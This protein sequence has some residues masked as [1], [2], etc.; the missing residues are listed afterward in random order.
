MLKQRP[1][2]FIIELDYHAEVLVELCRTLALKFDLMLWTTS[3]IWE[4]INLPA[5][6]FAHTFIMPKNISPAAYAKQHLTNLPDYDFV[7]FNTLERHFS[8]FLNWPKKCPWIIRI[9]NVNAS[10]FPQ[11]SIIWSL[12]T[13]FKNFRY[14]IQKVAI[15]RM[16]QTR[17]ALYHKIDSLMLPSDA[18][19][20]IQKSALPV[21]LAAKVANYCL[22]FSALS[23]PPQYPAESDNFTIAVTG[24]V[25]K[26]RKDYTVLLAAI[27]LFIYHNPQTHL[28][29]MFLGRVKGSKALR[30]LHPFKSLENGIFKV[31]YQMGYLPDEEFKIKMQKVHLLV[32]PI[33]L[34]AHHKIHREVYGLTKISGT[35]NDILRFQRPCILPLAYAISDDLKR[36]TETY[37]DAE[38]LCT[39]IAQFRQPGYWQ[40]KVQIFRQLDAYRADV[41]AQNFLA[42]CHTLNPKT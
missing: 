24:G 30:I 10:L 40:N 41:I 4:K 16:W 13:T 2:L 6:L 11:E 21:D 36:V 35:E 39:A 26:T 8:F 27:R 9:H 18:I 17:I 7:Y 25:D 42:Y 14:L 31:D 37:Q 23:E 34:Q 22:P 1:T 15:G 3:N 12:K 19:A 5:D 38:T 20:Q 32:A 28:T 29:L 33:Q